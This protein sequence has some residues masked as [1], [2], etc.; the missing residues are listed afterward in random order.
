MSSYVGDLFPDLLLEIGL[1]PKSEAFGTKWI[2]NLFWGY[3]F[4]DV[5]YSIW[6]W[7]GLIP[8][9]PKVE[10]TKLEMAILNFILQAFHNIFFCSKV[11]DFL[12]IAFQ[13]RPSTRNLDS[14]STSSK[15]VQQ[16]LSIDVVETVAFGFFLAFSNAGIFAGGKSFPWGKPIGVPIVRRLKISTGILDRFDTGSN[17]IFPYITL[18]TGNITTIP[19]RPGVGSLLVSHRKLESSKNSWSFF[20]CKTKMGLTLHFEAPCL[21]QR[22]WQ[23]FKLLVEPPEGKMISLAFAQL[24]D[25]VSTLPQSLSLA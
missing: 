9:N 21:L 7:S 1:S 3:K 18:I 23:F 11:L 10:D 17:N 14:K 12:T 15:F 6:N 8:Y 19:G 13:S 24:V 25:P 20:Q 16:A 2:A 22:A 4:L 5:R